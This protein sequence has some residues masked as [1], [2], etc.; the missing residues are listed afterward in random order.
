MPELPQQQTIKSR[1]MQPQA[2]KPAYRGLFL[3]PSL[4]DQMTEPEDDE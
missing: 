1:K 2:P 4:P 3:E